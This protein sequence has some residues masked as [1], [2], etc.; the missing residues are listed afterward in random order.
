[1]FLNHLWSGQAAEAFQQM[2]CGYLAQ[3]NWVQ[4]CRTFEQAYRLRRGIPWNENPAQFN[5]QPGPTP[6]YLAPHKLRHEAEQLRYLMAQ[7]LLPP[8]FAAWADIYWQVWLQ[9]QHLPSHQL[10]A[11]TQKLQTMWPPIY[12]RN[13]Y[14]EPAPALGTRALNERTDFTQLEEQFYAQNQV[15]WFDDLLTPTAWQSLYRFCLHSSIWNDHLKWPGFIGS[16]LED[17]FNCG[18]LYQIAKE[19]RQRLPRILGALPLRKTWAYKYANNSPGAPLHADAA[20][21]NVNFWLT[22]D[23]ANLEPQGGGM[24]VY[25]VE[26]PLEWRADQP[27]DF[28]L[29]EKWLRTKHPQRIPYR[30]NRVVIFHANWLHRTDPFLFR[31]EYPCRRLNVT[32]L[33]GDRGLLT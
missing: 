30:C 19:L 15:L 33:F 18:L 9:T 1:M 11:P 4:A 12:E 23:E 25:P 26:A 22:P 20:R 14:L 24:S 2:A 16:Y 21:I 17:G 32:M 28:E 3:E 8:A 29:M 31:P 7:G 6:Q 27:A 10:I 13:T 5:P